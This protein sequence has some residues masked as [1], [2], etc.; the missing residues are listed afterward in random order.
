VSVIDGESY[1]A[2]K[3]KKLSKQ[4][5]AVYDELY[6]S[7]HDEINEIIN[8]QFIK[9]IEIKLKIEKIDTGIPDILENFYTKSENIDKT[10][11]QLMAE[12][13][14]NISFPLQNKKQKTLNEIFP[15]QINIIKYNDQYYNKT[16]FN[17]LIEQYENIIRKMTEAK[18]NDI[19]AYI[20]F[21]SYNPEIELLSI[22]DFTGYKYYYET[23]SENFFEYY[24]SQSKITNKMIDEIVLSNINIFNASFLT[25]PVISIDNFY[26]DSF[27][28]N[29]LQESMKIVSPYLIQNTK[30]ILIKGIN[31]QTEI[32]SKNIDKYVSWYYSYFSGIDK[33][34]TNIVGFF[35]GEKSA[36]EKFYSDNFNR[37]M[38]N[39]ADF[40]YIV[41]NDLSRQNNIITNIFYEYL[42]LKDYFSVNFNQFAIKNISTSDFMEPF[43]E[44]ITTYFDHVF[45]ALDNADN[46]YLQEYTI[47]DDIAVKT[48][49]ASMKLLSSVNFIGG[50]LIDYLSLKTQEYLNNYELREQIYDSM[51][52]SQLNKIAIINDPF[53]YLYD[54]LSVGSAIFVDNYFA[55]FNTYQHYGVY[56]GN[57]KVIHFA[58]QE[59]KEISMENGVIHETSLE[60][61]LN[62][63]ALQIDK[64]IEKI[65]SDNE[66]VRRA[67][68]RLGEKGYDL[69]TNNCEHFARWCVTGEH[70]SYQINNLPEKIDDTLLIVHEK[71]NTFSK[72]LELFN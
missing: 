58:P 71:F 11:Y 50:I 66:I 36:G 5:A 13:N 65:F 2:N 68:S 30:N 54:K 22:S 56:I 3:L 46:Y 19:L 29:E 42:K 14:N 47:N 17:I 44:D 10:Y 38:N 63:R 21:Y 41:E 45:E 48:A 70:I 40:D 32:Y 31:F 67:R 62:G 15:A 52:K 59:G 25:I 28:I 51:I 7:L 57:G 64:N 49:K 8:N 12:C 18:T 4:R 20:N 53:N 6:I 34:I 72:F 35:K 24:L 43:I 1:N 23:K 61:F 16:A 60:K 33:T 9:P 39:N 27:S 26:F 69:F 37:I 55:G